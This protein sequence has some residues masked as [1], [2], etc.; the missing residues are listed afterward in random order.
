MELILASGNSHKAEEL[1]EMFLGEK[2]SV[3]AASEKIEVIEDGTSFAQ[4]AYK[5]ASGYFKRFKVPTIADDSGLVVNALPGELGI[6]SARFSPEFD[7]YQ[8]KCNFLIEKLKD[9][10]DK[11]AYFVCNICVYFSEEEYF[12]FEGRMQGAIAEST[13]GD[14]GFGYDPVFIP[15]G[16]APK[17]LAQ[18]TEWK[19]INSHRAKAVKFALAFL[20][21][22]NCQS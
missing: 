3:V 6:H 5:K 17:R 2:I 4:N 15:D 1:N 8:D 7:D 20:R 11:S 21:E 10:D 12:H 16:Q 18:L 9:L 22:R 13:C 14:G 19:A